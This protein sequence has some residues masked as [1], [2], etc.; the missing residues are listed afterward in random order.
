MVPR[1]IEDEIVALAALGKVL[2]GVINDLV[3]A[4]RLDHLQFPRAVHAGHVRSVRL[5]KLHGEGTH[6]TTRAVDQNLL[7]R[8][9]LSLMAKT[10]EG[11]E[12]GGR[13]GRGL[14]KRDVG[15]LQGQLLFGN[16][17]ILGI[18]SAV[19]PLPLTRCLAEYL[20]TWLKLRHVL[21]NRLNVPC[22]ICSRNTVL[23]FE[24]P[25]PHQTQGVGPASHDMPDIWM[26]GSRVNSYQYF[27]VLDH[28]LADFSEF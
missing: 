8:P 25:S 3:C 12:S 19:V 13:Y 14:F 11:D 1:N 6:T 26:D 5:G 18:G 2:L 23:W 24:Q 9:N 17:H 28:R 20:I 10:R 27:I 4:D 15:R 16:R 21:A 7:S 22:H